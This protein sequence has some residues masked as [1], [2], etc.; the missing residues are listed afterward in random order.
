MPATGTAH[1]SEYEFKGKPGNL[2]KMPIQIAPYHLRLDWLMW[3]AAMS[4]YREHPWFV[5]LIAKLL[6]NDRD[7]LSLMGANP[8]AQHA[9]R[10]IRAQIYL[11]QFTTP[12]ERRKTGN[13]WKRQLAG[14]YF[15]AVSLD[16]PAFHN[17]IVQ[18]GWE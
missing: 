4:D 15:P 8:F 2:A 18:Q 11:Y 14:R 16:D 9:P 3:F 10:F 1:W 7:T 5:H 13:W 17:L 6:Q 12:E